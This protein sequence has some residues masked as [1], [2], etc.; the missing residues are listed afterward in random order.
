MKIGEESI[1]VQWK[2]IDMKN[3]WI[4]FLV[5]ISLLFGLKTITISANLN[6]DDILTKINVERDAKSVNLMAKMDSY[7]ANGDKLEY[8]LKWISK[9]KGMD[10]FLVELS[11]PANLK[12]TTLLSQTKDDIN[13]DMYFYLSD[14][15]SS[16]KISGSQQNN[17]FLETDFN[18]ND[19]VTLNKQNYKQDYR[20]VILKETDQ[21]YL[22]QI[23]P[24]D[25]DIEYNYGKMWVAK[26]NWY[27]VKIEFYDEKGRLH[28]VLTNKKIKKID[29]YWTAQQVIMENYQKGSK[30]VLN[31]DKI[32]YDQKIEDQ[33]F[34]IDKLSVVKE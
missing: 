24:V 7:D 10:K 34:K 14:S 6:G 18:Y 30:T 9:N 3:R 28:K 20:A 31:L 15:D 23:I 17:S 26:K 22:L 32:K 11:A 5:L 16:K 29:G 1:V 13:K 4:I 8:K 21:K 12:G 2:V 19:L 25:A 27:P 33:L